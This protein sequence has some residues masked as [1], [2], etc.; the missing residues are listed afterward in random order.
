[1]AISVNLL[2]LRETS[3]A[4]PRAKKGAPPQSTTGV[5]STSWSQVSARPVRWSPSGLPGIISPIAIANTGSVRARL[6][7]KRR[8]MPRN[9]GFGPSSSAAATGS[10]AMPQIGQSPGLSFRTSGCI[11]HVHCPTW[12]AAEA[13][14]TS[15]RVARAPTKRAGSASNFARQPAEQNE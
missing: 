9:S 8:V 10:R 11:G 6:T 3:E 14:F 5:A 12:A 2:R 1:M 13:P 4:Q 15:D 7:Q